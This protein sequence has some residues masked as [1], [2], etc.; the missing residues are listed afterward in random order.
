MN[1]SKQHFG[2]WKKQS[3]FVKLS[4]EYSMKFLKIQPFQ[5]QVLNLLESPGSQLSVSLRL[6][7]LETADL[8]GLPKLKK[9]DVDGFHPNAIHFP[10]E[11]LF[12]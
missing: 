1:A 3:R 7:R 8:R 4:K 2:Q 6:D 10:H 11:I 5:N 12:D 9:V